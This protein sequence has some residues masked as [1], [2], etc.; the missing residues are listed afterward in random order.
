MYSLPSVEVRPAAIVA[1]Q[2]GATRKNRVVI[3]T[4]GMDSNKL[5]AMLLPNEEA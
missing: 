4:P 3:P 5:E 2:I 1:V